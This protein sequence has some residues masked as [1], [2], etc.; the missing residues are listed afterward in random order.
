M[1]S[2]WL[3]QRDNGQRALAFLDKCHSAHLHTPYII[4]KLYDTLVSIVGG[5][6]CEIWGPGAILT[7]LESLGEINKNTSHNLF[8]RQILHVG[9]Q[10]CIATM[11]HILNR[12]PVL[13]TY[14]EKALNF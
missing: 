10:T 1:V 8:M 4:S 12:S 5:Y 3:S 9:K 11:Q 14:L 13:T 6:G 2:A 7:A